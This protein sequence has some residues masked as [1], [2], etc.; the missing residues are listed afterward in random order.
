M[1][2]PFA[3]FRTLKAKLRQRCKYSSQG[4]IAE[5]K[6]K[7]THVSNYS[8]DECDLKLLKMIKMKSR[9]KLKKS[10]SFYEPSHQ[11]VHSPKR[12][13]KGDKISCWVPP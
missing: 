4:E 13:T 5:R 8:K 9:G 3:D 6:V 12:S 10:F 7:V 2:S 1:S 11:D